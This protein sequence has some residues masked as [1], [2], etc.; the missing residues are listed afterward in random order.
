LLIKRHLEILKGSIEAGTSLTQGVSYV[1]NGTVPPTKEHF[2]IWKRFKTLGIALSCDALGPQ[3]EY[4]RYGARWDDFLANYQALRS[5]G[6]PL[7]VNFTCSI[8]NVLSLPDYVD[9][10]ANRFT[11]ISLTFAD[12]PDHF[13]LNAMPLPLKNAV[14]EYLR[15]HPLYRDLRIKEHA[16]RAIDY[17]YLKD[18]SKVWNN[19]VHTI[20][21]H[22]K[23]RQ[24]NFGKTF[25]EMRDLIDRLGLFGEKR[26][27]FCEK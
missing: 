5:E 7:L 26:L 21:L 8:F 23:F 14:A 12:Q 16:D 4:L 11:P 17:M 13:S 27:S 19:T 24:E 25:P 3:F 10:F 18:Y 2:D 22:D 1:T 20:E 9:F 6:I 15:Q